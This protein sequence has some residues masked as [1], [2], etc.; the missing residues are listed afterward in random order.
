MSDSTHAANAAI[1]AIEG[2]LLR[3]PSGRFT[4]LAQAHLDQLLA[5][6][7]EQRVEIV[8][9][10]A[11]PYTKGTVRAN[12]DYRPGDVF[13]Y[14]I[15]D[16]LTKNIERTQVQ[17]VVRVLPGQVFFNG[18]RLVTDR[19]GNFLRTP[20]GATYGPNQFY[21]TEYAVGR[22]WTTRYSTVL[23]R[24]EDDEFEIDFKVTG[25]ESVVV[26]AGTFDAFRVE[27]AGWLLG[28]SRSINVTYW[29]AP[30]R[31]PRAIAIESWHRHSKRI[32]KADRLE[33]TSYS[34]L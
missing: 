24:G 12:L 25:R 17:R 9:S 4:E 3:Y 20:N 21:A 31:V 29:M 2:Y 8:S 22:K 18:G 11:N 30:E 15:I 14:Q 19:L 7:G 6:R 34:R 10:A 13:E 27:G 1:A 28:K 5:E 23:P 33:L 26:P 32:K 16:L